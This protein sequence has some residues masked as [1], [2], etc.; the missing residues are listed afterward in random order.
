MKFQ[1]TEEGEFRYYESGNGDTVLLLLHGLFGA[2]SNFREVIENFSE[3]M[4]VCIPLLPLYTL[5]LKETTVEGLVA[6]TTRFIE[7]KKY[8]SL[9]LLGNSLGG[10]IALLYAL[11][12][13][14]QN[15]VKSIVLTGSSGLFEN[16]LGDTYP[17]KS[18]YDFVRQKTADTF[19]DPQIATK[20]LVDEVFEI[21]NNREKALRILNLAKSALRNNL[22][23]RLQ[24]IQVPVLLIWGKDDKITPPFVA[25][26]FN[27]LLPNSQLHYI[28]K[29]GHAAM[30][31]QSEKFNLLL[32]HF[33]SKL[34]LTTQ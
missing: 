20:E 27:K 18:D 2:L 8:K 25:D 10:H 17:R 23:E 32:E 13:Q 29:C 7:F 3:K 6:Y 30:M 22:R 5:P 34:L 11:E 14:D 31:E 9:I 24:N 4:K 15:K 19:Y 16:T 26:E 1:I 12:N 33:L 28:E 21:V